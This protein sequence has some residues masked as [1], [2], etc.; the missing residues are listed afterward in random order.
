M[1]LKLN[2]IAD[3]VVAKNL[4]WRA[5]LLKKALL[6]KPP[7]ASDAR[8][9]DRHYRSIGESSCEVGLMLYQQE[10][11]PK[12]IREHLTLAGRNLL[13]MHAVRQKPAPSESRILWVFE[14]TLSLVICFCGPAEREELLRLQ[15]W[16]FR[17]PVEPSDDAYAGYLE[18]V[19]LYLRKS[20][21]DPAAIEELIA[22]CSSDTA[23]K[24]DRQSV[25]PEVQALRA[26]ATQ[27]TKLLDE[28]LAEVVKAHEVQAKRGELKLRSEGFICLPA[29]ALAKLAQER[30]MQCG[31][32]SPYLPLFLLEG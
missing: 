4:E 3:D 30:G 9:L 24:D 28:S 29:M 5:G 16:Q 7:A 27:D 18:Q 13:K 19:R 10:K 6:E 26:V 20:A 32:K 23:S 1:G 14:K 25:L 12:Q 2:K 15:P 17:N 21:V 22:K 31:V 11:D 8:E